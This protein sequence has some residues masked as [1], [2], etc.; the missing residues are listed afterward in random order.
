VLARK[1]AG[2]IEVASVDGSSFRA[3]V[4]DIVICDN[5]GQPNGLLGLSVPMLEL[6]PVQGARQ[7]A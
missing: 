7:V 6:V 5:Q 4:R 1:T 3:W 2:R